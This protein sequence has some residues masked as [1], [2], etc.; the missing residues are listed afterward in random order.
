M[1]IE[2]ITENWGELLVLLLVFIK[3]VLNLIPSEQPTIVF[4]LIDFLIDQIVPNRTKQQE[5]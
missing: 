2:F 1:A 5:G 4:S 3:G